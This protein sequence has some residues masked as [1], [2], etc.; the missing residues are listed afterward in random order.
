MLL[1][2]TYIRDSGPQSNWESSSHG[3]TSVP[4]LAATVAGH[5]ASSNRC[6]H[7]CRCLQ[8]PPPHPISVFLMPP[9]IA[10]P[11]L[12]SLPGVATASPSLSC[13]QNGLSGCPGLGR[14]PGQVS[15]ARWDR[16]PQAAT[17]VSVVSSASPQPLRNAHREFDD[18]VMATATSLEI[19]VGPGT[20]REGRLQRAWRGGAYC[21]Y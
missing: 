15:P 6:R 8:G 10:S 9:L 21:R 12:A 20:G 13:S 7:R 5:T 4:R 3:S 16:P 14:I 18:V 17:T 1:I 19:K 11:A 2:V